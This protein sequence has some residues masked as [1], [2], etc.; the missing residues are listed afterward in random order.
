VRALFTALKP[1][2][3][4]ALYVSGMSALVVAG[5]LFTVIAGCLAL[6]VALLAIGY[7]AEVNQ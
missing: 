7:M 3:P 6:G 2:A 4:G 5:F 1:A